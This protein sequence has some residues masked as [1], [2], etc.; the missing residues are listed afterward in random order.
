VI[1]RGSAI[2]G[3]HIDLFFP[4]HETAVAWGKQRIAVTVVP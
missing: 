4:D 3:N 1:D 2:K